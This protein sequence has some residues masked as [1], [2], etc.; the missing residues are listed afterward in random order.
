MILLKKTVIRE[1]SKFFYKKI[2]LGLGPGSVN[3]K[4]RYESG[5][6]CSFHPIP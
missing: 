3:P 4:L 1:S 5:F 6:I 2:D